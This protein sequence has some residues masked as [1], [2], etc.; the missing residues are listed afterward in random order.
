MQQKQDDIL[1]IQSV[2]QG[3]QNAYATIVD[4]YQVFVFTLVLR[5]IKDRS[6]AEELAQDIFVKAYRCLADFKGNSKFSTWLYTIV[7]TTCLSQLRKRKDETLFVENEK[8]S[9][10]SDQFHSHDRADLHLE[11]KTKRQ[12]LANAIAALPSEDAQLITLFYQ[13]GQ[14][15]EEIAKILGLTTGNVKAKLYRAR[16]RLRSIVETK[17]MNELT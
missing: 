10:L 8:L 15:Q 12:A 16:L 1:I 9:S 5:Y 3:D 14:S 4:R 17:F 2:L 6:L 11:Q 13:A 7:H